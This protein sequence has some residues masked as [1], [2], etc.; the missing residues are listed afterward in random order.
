MSAKDKNAPEESNENDLKERCFVITPIG[1]KGEPIRRHIDGVIQ[2]AIRP[3]LENSGYQVIAAH[4]MRESGAIDKQIFRELY[5]DKLV[6]ANLTQNNPNV[7]YELAARHCFGK[8][9]II[10]AE[11]GSVLPFDI[12]KERAIFY[13]NDGL[14]M[15][16][17]RNELRERLDKTNF[18]QVESP[19]HDLIL[20]IKKDAKV[21]ADIENG[22]VS[23]SDGT[24]DREV[25]V[26][27]LEKLEDLETKIQRS[28]QNPIE[29]GEI[30]FFRY[31][32]RFSVE[33][34]A[35]MELQPELEMALM[36][37]LKLRFE[38]VRGIKINLMNDELSIE[39]VSR[40]DMIPRVFRQ[41]MSAILE[42]YG[43]KKVECIG[44]NRMALR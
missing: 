38:A 29:D 31:Y 13:V 36:R 8:P 26:H 30:I 27:I 22:K 3:A 24:T 32:C 2:A 14:G 20:G 5:E 17:L 25:M 34:P 10:I 35:G 16:E 21:Y 42:Q 41:K 19:I 6:I 23:K 37:E 7:L 15:L 11:E 39:F 1:S 4:T 44:T 43:F 12:L 18:K 40:I 33:G 28:T 9:V